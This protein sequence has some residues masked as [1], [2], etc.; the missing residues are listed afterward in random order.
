MSEH[1]YM[2]LYVNAK[3]AKPY[4]PT[5]TWCA[6]ARYQTTE[7]LHPKIKSKFVPD[8]ILITKREFI[9]DNF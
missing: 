6:N 5:S 8:E 2:L 9:K 1:N 3:G 7:L 4:Q